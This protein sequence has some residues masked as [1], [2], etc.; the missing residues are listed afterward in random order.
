M[1]NAVLLDNIQFSPVPVPEP[2]E[3]ALAALGAVFPGFR[4]WRN[5][6]DSRRLPR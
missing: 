1:E 4:R 2:S 5:S 6:S 3:F